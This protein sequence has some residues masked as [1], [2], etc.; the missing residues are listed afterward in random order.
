MPRADY[1]PRDDAG[2][3]ALFLH[4]RDTLPTFLAPLGLLPTNPQVLAQAADALAFDYMCRAQ[5]ILIPAGQEATATKN[6]LRD[7][8]PSSPNTPVALAFPSGPGTAPPAVTPG[9]VPRFRAFA[10]WIKSLP[11]YTVAIG[12]AL[13]I[14]GPESTGPDLA[15]VKPVLPL[16]LNGGQVVIAWGWGGHKGA[17]DACEIHVD[18]GSGFALLTI[19]TRPGYVD[20]EPLPAGGARWR[21]KAIFRADDSRVGLW[22]DVAEI[23]VG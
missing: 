19:D 9:V 17:L 14:E 18:R 22:S 12:E 23:T 4:V 20:T 13:Q 21:Y 1:V 15:T 10:Q 8:D 6:R 16:S 5:A 3:C 7:G 2:K 11:T